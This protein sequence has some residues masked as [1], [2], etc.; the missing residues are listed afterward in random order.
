MYLQE[1][2]WEGLDRIGLN[3]S[4]SGQGQVV[5]TCECGNE[6]PGSV[7]CGDFLNQLRAY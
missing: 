4:G 7:K 3:C 1:V 2:E 5:G 6:P